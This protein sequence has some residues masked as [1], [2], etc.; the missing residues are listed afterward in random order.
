M[1]IPIQNIYYLL[2]YAWNKLDEKDLVNVQEGDSN[3]LIDLFAKVL[4][5]GTTYLLKRGLD[6]YYVE[7][8]EDFR[9]I[10]GKLNLDLSIKR[11]LLIQRKTHCSFDEFSHNILHNQILRTTIYKLIRT[12]GL[13]KDLKESLRQLLWKLSDI[14]LIEISSSSFTRVKLNKNNYFYDFLLNICQIIHE[15]I[16]I[17]EETGNYK[18]RDFIRDEN[19][20]AYVFEEFVRNF[21]KIELDNCKV[22]REDIKWQLI[23]KNEESMNFLPKMQTDI[24]IESKDQ[25]F[26]IDTKYYKST[27][28]KHSSYDVEKIHSNNLYQLFAYL[29][30]IENRSELDNN[31]IGMLLYPTVDKE[32]N[33]D[34]RQ[35]NQRV[36]IRTINLYKH[37]KDIRDDLLELVVE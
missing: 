35:N 29:K 33:L 30:N 36:L 9:G 31:C 20:M 17:N 27:L 32:V 2:C 22:R 3:E 10:K 6:R 13:D 16:F 28:Q 11:N 25:K 37:W 4:I 5:N 23:P 1:S 19:K 24:T 14:D 15:S 12:D 7:E 21:Y 18:F 34:Y 8:N 26:I